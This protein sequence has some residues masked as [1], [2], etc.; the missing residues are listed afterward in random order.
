MW[1]QQVPELRGG[2][3]NYC[4]NKHPPRKC[5]AHGQ[6]CNNC[7]GNNHYSCVCKSRAST[8]SQNCGSEKGQQNRQSRPKN[9]SS[10]FNEVTQD[11]YND[12]QYD[13]YDETRLWDYDSVMMLHYHD[14]RIHSSDQHKCKIMCNLKMTLDGKKLCLNQC[15]IERC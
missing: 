6:I 2:D 11:D 9:K 10:N 8:Y 12:V 15:K 4:G 7:N 1:S 5:P 13:D 14:V 3:C